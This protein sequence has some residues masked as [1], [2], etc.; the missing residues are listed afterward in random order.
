MNTKNPATRG[1]GRPRTVIDSP[2]TAQRDR[3]AR[4]KVLG[5]KFVQL[6]VP[7]DKVEALQAQVAKWVAAEEKKAAKKGIAFPP[8]QEPPALQ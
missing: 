7:A 4:R 5:L 3:T 2:H 6:D 8:A 1:R